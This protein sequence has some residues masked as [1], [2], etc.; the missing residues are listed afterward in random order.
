LLRDD[1]TIRSQLDEAESLNIINAVVEHLSKEPPLVWA[2]D[3][4]V[5]DSDERSDYIA[6]LRQADQL[7]YAFLI[8]Y[9]VGKNGS[10]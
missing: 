2:T 10:R 1:I 7:E 5:K 6:A 4:L 3:T 8:D 9:L